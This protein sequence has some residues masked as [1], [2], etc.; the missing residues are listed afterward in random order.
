MQVRQPCRRDAFT[1]VEL[2][3]VIAIIGMLMALLFPAVNAARE[4]GRTTVCSNNMRNLA[5]AIMQYESKKNHYPA[6][7]GNKYVRAN[8]FRERPLIYEVLPELGQG[9]LYNRYRPFDYDAT[10]DPMGPNEMIP[11]VDAAGN[12]SGNY[13]EI[14][15]CPSDPQVSSQNPSPLSYVFNAG[16]VIG[17]TL[18]QNNK[19]HGV[20]FEFGGMSSSSVTN[21]DGLGTTLMLSENL[22]AGDWNVWYDPYM[23]PALPAD[24]KGWQV[25]FVW[26]DVPDNP[27]GTW[28]AHSINGRNS[29][30]NPALF[31]QIA[32]DYNYAR[33]SSNHGGGVNVAFCDGNVR[34]LNDRVEYKVYVQL[35]TPNSLQAASSASPPIDVRFKLQENQY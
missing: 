7:F 33:P 17:G 31:D 3:V 2:L 28:A 14:L 21:N 26:W 30:I 4:R 9:N 20:F 12:P 6:I 29:A 5:L 18:E 19:A 15:V 32:T 8:E 11:D 25:E 23:P 10:L 1:L 27:V 13:L 35:M 22:D 34:F 24:R 16:R